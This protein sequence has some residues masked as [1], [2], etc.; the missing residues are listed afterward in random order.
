MLEKAL[1]SSTFKPFQKRSLFTVSIHIFAFVF[2]LLSFHFH[3]VE[4]G[5]L[6]SRKQG[7]KLQRPL[8]QSSPGCNTQSKKHQGD[9]FCILLKWSHEFISWRLEFAWLK[10][11][12]QH[13]E[14]KK[15][16]IKNVSSVPNQN[17]CCPLWATIDFKATIKNIHILWI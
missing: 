16:E 17:P 8:F 5:V 10:V 2:D 13:S 12:Q 7:F 4:I 14:D 11:K 3:T 15:N 9:F 1:P 6:D